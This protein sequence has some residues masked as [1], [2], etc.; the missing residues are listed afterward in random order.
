MERWRRI[1]VNILYFVADG[2]NEYNSS[3]WRVSTPYNAINGRDW[4]HRARI[5]SAQAWLKQTEEAVDLC[6]WADLISIQR[7]AIDTSFTSIKYWRSQGKAVVIDYDDDYFRI[8]DSNA[9]YKFWGDGNV[10][11]TIADGTKFESPMKTHPVKQFIEGLKACTA[12]TMPSSLL[13][14]DA[15]KYGATAFF[16]PN[17][18][19]KRLYPEPNKR[20]YDKDRIVIGWGGSLS[21][22]ESFE[23]SGIIP[24]LKEILEKK[25]NI[26]LLIV[27][28][29]RVTKKLKD[30]ELR[31]DRLLHHPYVS[32]DRW[33]KTLQLYD[34]GIA[35]LAM[36][37]D[38]R[39]SWIKV[40]EYMSMGIPFVATNG[41]PYYYSQIGTPV[42]GLFVSQGDKD[43][44]DQPSETG[45]EQALTATINNLEL[46][47]KEAV[48][49]KD[50][51][52]E[53]FDIENNVESMISIYQEIINLEKDAF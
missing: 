18:L 4:E 38:M 2:I 33:Y 16:I 15:R 37:Y 39:R 49:N 48:K 20:P 7:V 28:D 3:R 5:A 53:I 45:W 1:L 8:N 34:I 29:E 50:N 32:Y 25:D 21:H 30:L 26:Y 13:A 41:A 17:F 43:K 6:R 36:E 51:Y 46:L 35:P 47:K 22:L 42:S 23:Y 52:F 19:E 12:A 31:N 44:S 10:D 24:A 40:A 27:G 14:K 9:A 11:I